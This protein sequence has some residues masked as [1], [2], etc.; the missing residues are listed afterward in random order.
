METKTV[1]GLDEFTL[2][3]RA[4]RLSPVTVG[5]RVRVLRQF[6]ADTGIQ[7]IRASAVDVMEWQAAHD[8]TWSDSTAATYHSYLAAWFK[9][10][11]LTDRRVD[12]PMVKVGTP[13]V[14]ERDPRPL[15]DTEVVVL[16]QAPSANSRP[17][18]PVSM[19]SRSVRA[20]RYRSSL[21]S[22]M[23]SS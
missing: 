17:S 14:P 7:P 4:Q 11:Q 15:A 18:A 8:D 19:S 16:L 2:W 5:E 1:L 10:L 20:L 9:W 12:N 3:Q 13:R 22:F 21:Q 23:K 6:H